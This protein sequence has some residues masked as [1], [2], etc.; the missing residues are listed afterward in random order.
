[1]KNISKNGFWMELQVHTSCAGSCSTAVFSSSYKLFKVTEDPNSRKSFP[2]EIC[3]ITQHLKKH[4]KTWFN[5]GTWTG[6]IM[7]GNL[8][9]LNLTSIPISVFP[10]TSLA[11]GFLACKIHWNHR[12]LLALISSKSCRD[13]GVYHSDRFPLMCRGAI[14]KFLSSSGKGRFREGS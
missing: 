10:L 14:L 5:S 2:K 7:T 3:N 6:E 4:K 13:V 9:L 12:K 8:C 1:M 11:C